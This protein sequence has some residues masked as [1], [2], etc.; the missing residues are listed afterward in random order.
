MT[1]SST[2][3]WQQQLN[4]A[5]KTIPSLCEYLHLNPD[6]IASAAAQ[7]DFTLRVPQSFAAC[8]Q[9][10][11]PNDPLL[12]QVLPNAAELIEQV[13]FSA[14]PVGDL[15]A[16]KDFGVIHKY[17]GRVLLITTGAC[18]IHCRYCFRRN[19]PYS[20][21]QLNPSKQQQAIEYIQQHTEI[22]EVILSGGDPLLLSDD[23][24]AQL[25]SQLE[26]ISHIKRIRLH[27]RLPVVL[28]ARITATLLSRFQ[29]SS[30]Q[31]IIVI[32]CNHSQELSME[33][34]Q[35]CQKI[36]QHDITLLNQTVLLQGINDDAK[37]LCQ[38]SEQLFAANVLPYYLH[39][40]DKAQG[41]AHFSVSETIASQL[42]QQMQANLP[43]YLVPK[44]VQEQTGANSKTLIF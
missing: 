17:H 27:S 1:I 13:G 40:L 39:I 12:K 2:H 26:N 42:F 31:I 22:S 4:T 6:K 23:K 16:T 44:L 29:Y 30:K 25:L 9:K 32:H 7:Q 33:V 19:F 20:E 24:L 10:N 18:A 35:T 5:F 14:D 3:T 36:K 38:L 21:I 37:Q 11:N 15:A 8:M 41:T 43:G 34:V 28:P